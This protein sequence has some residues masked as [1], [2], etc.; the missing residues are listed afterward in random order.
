MWTADI[1]TGITERIYQASHKD[2]ES[3]VVAWISRRY[4]QC[5]SRWSLQVEK[6][7]YV[8]MISW[9]DSNFL[10]KLL[11]DI[12]LEQP[13]FEIILNQWNYSHL[14]IY[15]EDKTIYS[16]LISESD[17]FDQGELAEDLNN[18]FHYVNN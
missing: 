2:G 14:G 11:N 5:L 8:R 12:C 9:S 3:R 15:T 4:L 13:R 18:D 10:I 16:C 1:L 7:L 6:L 17:R